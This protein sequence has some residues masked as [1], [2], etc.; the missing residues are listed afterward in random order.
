MDL[1][2]GNQHLFLKP[3]LTSHGCRTN[4][5]FPSSLVSGVDLMQRGLLGFPVGH[6]KYETVQR[7]TTELQYELPE[8]YSYIILQ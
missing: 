8:V 6:P 5:P 4:S 7:S 3:S 1:V 2:A